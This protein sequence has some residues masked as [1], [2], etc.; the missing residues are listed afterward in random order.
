MSISQLLND[1]SYNLNANSIKINDIHN[2]ETLNIKINNTH[3]RA[4]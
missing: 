3:I 1:N 4:Y 2:K